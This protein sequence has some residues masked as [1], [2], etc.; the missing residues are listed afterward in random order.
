MWSLPMKGE[1][2]PTKALFQDIG[3]YGLYLRMTHVNSK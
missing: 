2:T 3:A 1:D